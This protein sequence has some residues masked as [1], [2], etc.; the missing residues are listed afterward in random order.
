MELCGEYTYHLD[1]TVGVD[2]LS[3]GVASADGC[4][5]RLLYLTVSGGC[6]QKGMADWWLWSCTAVE[7]LSEL[8]K[9]TK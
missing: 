9:A 2:R 7:V 1:G 5:N 8:S 3:I 4:F 6:V